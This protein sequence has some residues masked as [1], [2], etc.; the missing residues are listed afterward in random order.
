MKSAA[1]AIV[2]WTILAGGV[3]WGQ[4]EPGPNSTQPGMRHTP[5][6]L[7]ICP[8][9]MQANVHAVHIGFTAR[10][11]TVREEEGV[12]TATVAVLRG[13]LA[14]DTPIIVTL[15]TQDGSA[16]GIYSNPKP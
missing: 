12:V 2:I 1:I 4:N 5:N 3:V 7:S 13:Q 11:Y 9:V 10:E 14:N 8:N 6:K 15:E 16:K